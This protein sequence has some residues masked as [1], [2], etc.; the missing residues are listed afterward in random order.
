MWRPGVVR[1]TLPT[2]RLETGFSIPSWI[3]G[4]HGD[5]RLD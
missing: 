3:D 5:Y 4:R 2:V 1:S